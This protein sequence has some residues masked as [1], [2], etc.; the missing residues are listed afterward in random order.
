M[1]NALIKQRVENAKH[2]QRKPTKNPVPNAALAPPAQ[3]TSAQLF[4]H[5]NQNNHYSIIFIAS[6]TR[7]MLAQ[8]TRRS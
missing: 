4:N 5:A 8:H 3:F 6:G 2:K 7:G 1:R